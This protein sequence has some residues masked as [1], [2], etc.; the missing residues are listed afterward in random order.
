M[1]RFAGS[2]IGVVPSRII[3]GSSHSKK[4]KRTSF[5]DSVDIGFAQQNGGTTGG[6][7]GI[8]TTVSTY[9]VVVDGTISGSAKVDVTSDKATIG[10]SGSDLESVGFTIYEQSDVIVHNLKIA[11]AST[12]VLIDHVDVFS[13]MDH[14]KNYYD[15]LIGVSCGSYRI[16]ISNCYLYDHLEDVSD[17]ENIN[18]RGPS[19]RFGTGHIFNS[20]YSNANTVIN[21]RIGAQLLIESVVFEN[22]GGDGIYSADSDTTEYAVVRD[23]DL[24]GSTNPASERTLTT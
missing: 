14:D 5:A 18:S 9:V 19:F 2:V 4:K 22:C 15:G 24:G 7:G 8:T 23:V 10:T 21:T 3:G 6:S 17:F 11:K 1:F 13:D 12:N 16:T 20:Y